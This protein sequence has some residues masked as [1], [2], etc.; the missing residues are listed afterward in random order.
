MYSLLH[1]SACKIFLLQTYYVSVC[2]AIWSSMT[3]KCNS[4]TLLGDR[5]S[6]GEKWQAC[7]P[8][9]PVI[10]LNCASANTII[11]RQVS[12]TAAYVHS[13]SSLQLCYFLCYATCSKGVTNRVDQPE[14]TV[15]QLQDTQWPSF[16]NVALKGIQ[17]GSKCLKPS[18]KCISFCQ[19]LR[20]VYYEWQL[21]VFHCQTKSHCTYCSHCS[22]F[23]KTHLR[24]LRDFFR[25]ESSLP[26]HKKFVIL[27][28][29]ALI[30]PHRL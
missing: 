16:S 24:K 6:L 10:L 4:S 13:P 8:K 21:E 5:A 20:L 25:S 23:Y 15:G 30:W 14:T 12:Q 28:V 18:L 3:V 27:S 1:N 19:Q 2:Y 22:Q 26:W 17:I 7:L 11:Y 9:S 29:A